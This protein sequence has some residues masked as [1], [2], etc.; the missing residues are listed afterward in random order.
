MEVE[1]VEESAAAAEIW[2]WR[3]ERPSI[4]GGAV[5]NDGRRRRGKMVVYPIRALAATLSKGF[6]GRDGV[7][8]IENH[9]AG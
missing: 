8:P 7:P 9:D 1:G 4:G 6:T 3:R 5:A 2:E